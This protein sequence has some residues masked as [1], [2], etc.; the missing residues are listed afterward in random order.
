MK[1][2]LDKVVEEY[3]KIIYR[4]AFLYFKQ[5][6]EAEDV[7]Q[8]VLL[9]YLMNTKKFESKEH[10]KNWIIRVT[11]NHCHNVRLSAWKR[12]TVPLEEYA[13]KLKTEIQDEIFNCLD[14]L[15]EKYRV[16]A[17][18]F[19]FED[20][21]IKQISKTLKISESNVKTRLLRARHMLRDELKK[22][23]EEHWID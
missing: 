4:I 5:R 18:L 15:K 21:S 13:F 11:I 10:E 2:E 9:K 6:T 7:V 8:D 1:E 12:K 14:N 16:V 17:Q 19:Y 3:G 20:L 23:D 22:G